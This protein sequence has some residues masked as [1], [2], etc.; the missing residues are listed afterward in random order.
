MKLCIG[1]SRRCVPAKV[2]QKYIERTPARTGAAGSRRCRRLDAVQCARGGRRGRGEMRG[3]RE[4]KQSATG[5][6]KTKWGDWRVGGE[7]VGF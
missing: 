5:F 4:L 7:W 2:L 6:P 1:H 3:G